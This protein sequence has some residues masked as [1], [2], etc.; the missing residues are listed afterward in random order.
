[1]KAVRQHRIVEVDVESGDYAQVVELGDANSRTLGHLP[2]AVF[3]EAAHAGCLLAACLGERV[4]GY[5]LFALRSKRH[6]ISLTHLCV[7]DSERGTGVARLLVQEIVDRHSDRLGIRLRCR[8]DYDAH[9]LWPRLGFDEW[10]Q[11]PGR[12]KAGLPLATW[13]LPI[14]S[15]TL[16]DVDQIEQAPAHRVLL[17]L[18]TNV[19]LDIELGRDHLPSRALAADWVGEVAELAVVPQVRAE[20]SGQ[21]GSRGASRHLEVGIE[22]HELRPSESETQRLS[23]ELRRS[24]AERPRGDADLQIV[25]EARA[26]GATYLATRDEGLL[27]AAVDIEAAIGL[28]VVN[29]AD[30]L[31][32]LHMGEADRYSPEAI[33]TAQFTIQRRSTVPTRKELAPMAREHLGEL[34]GS[35]V[36]SLHRVVAHD[37]PGRIEEVTDGGTTLATVGYV[38]DAGLL[39][40]RVLVA[41]SHRFTYSLLRHLAHALR[42]RAIE[43]GAYRIRLASEIQALSETVASALH[44]E[45]YAVEEGVWTA[46]V[47]QAV[48]G[49]RDNEPLDFAEVEVADLSA[50]SV[51]H[52]E[53]SRWPLKAFGGNV[54]CLVVPI[55]PAYGRTLLGYPEQAMTLLDPSPDA[56]TARENAYYMSPRE[57]LS[58]PARILWWVTGGGSES[59]MRAMSWL[60]AYETGDP[61]RLYRKYRRR[62]VFELDQVRAS[63]AERRDGRHRAT[64]LLF[65]RTD[66]FNA[67][68]PIADAR[69]LCPAMQESGFFVTARRVEESVAEAFYRVGMETPSV[70]DDDV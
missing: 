23:E 2:Y 17:A 53:L 63:A 51:S 62:G 49:G 27:H 6:E 16:F 48:V 29:P 42:S 50:A 43:L 10:S 1:M 11:Q 4:V 14:A 45:G 55:R 44:D 65:S 36:E 18:D 69:E 12:S 54:P 52:L 30:A 61:D 21:S 31:L 70:A 15:W 34:P 3:E 46:E 56:A 7:E 28:H 8:T 24:M 22:L 25:A 20:L 66:V 26:G 39:E 40:V 60:D 5:A 59:G 13:W 33:A 19:L 58:V 67:P 32:M 38:C 68:I 9:H 35:L 47:T 37:P 57:S 41:R 64:V